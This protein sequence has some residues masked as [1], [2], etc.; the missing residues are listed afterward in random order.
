MNMMPNQDFANNLE[1]TG[2]DKTNGSN[3]ALARL[4]QAWESK[5]GKNAKKAGGLGLIAVSLSAC[6]SDSDPAPSEPDGV[7]QIFNLMIGLITPPVGTVLFAIQKITDLPFNT[8]VRATLPFY[9]PLVAV[10]IVITLFPSIVMFLPN[11]LLK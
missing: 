2:L 9:I 5:Q 6:G 3:P 10:L 8:L 4:M 7:G 11:L 1:A